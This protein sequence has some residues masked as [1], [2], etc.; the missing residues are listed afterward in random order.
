[1]PGTPELTRAAWL[2][3]GCT[4]GGG[5]SA[6]DTTPAMPASEQA[7]TSAARRMRV[8]CEGRGQR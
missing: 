2:T 8:P 7:A 5:V 3:A 6:I 1:M 4:T